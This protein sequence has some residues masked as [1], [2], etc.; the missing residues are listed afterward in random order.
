MNQEEREVEHQWA[1][2]MVALE[3]E[4][5]PIV[6]GGAVGGLGPKTRK[7]RSAANRARGSV[8]F[9]ARAVPPDEQAA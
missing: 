7:A 9:L 3:E 4:L 1:L 5:G 2:R 8:R 6:P